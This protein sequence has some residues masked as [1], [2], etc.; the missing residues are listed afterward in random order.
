[1]NRTK[2][3]LTI[4]FAFGFLLC[5]CS[6]HSEAPSDIQSN[7][8]PQQESKFDL[9]VSLFQLDDQG[10]P[11]KL[12]SGTVPVEK[13][14]IR[15]LEAL[16]YKYNPGPDSLYFIEAR[17]GSID[18]K[19]AILPEEQSVGFASDVDWGA[20]FNE[21]PVMIQEW[22]P[23]IQQIRS[24]NVSCVQTVQILVRE[25]DTDGGKIVYQ[26][27]PMP[28]TTEYTM[29]C[30]YSADSKAGTQLLKENILK[31]FAR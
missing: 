23:K 1:M 17:V 28:I 27:F 3:F 25:Q 12:E 10:N 19:L 26:D 30:P 18:P 13:E 21:Y 2:R 24:G 14:I 11:V 7:F 8:A 16:G 4:I 9:Q 29:G 6:S 15:A 20:D 22:S 5:G 31:I